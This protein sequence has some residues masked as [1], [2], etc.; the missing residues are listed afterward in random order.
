MILHRLPPQNGSAIV[1]HYNSSKSAAEELSQEISNMGVK[2]FTVAADLESPAEASQLAQKAWDM[3][4]P[5]DVL[6]N[7]ASIFET[8]QFYGYF[9]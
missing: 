2:A 3:A 8:S 1:I 4:G 9:H 7:N 6:I 5:I